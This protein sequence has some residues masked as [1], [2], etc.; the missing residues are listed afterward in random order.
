MRALLML[1]ILILAAAPA[2]PVE[3]LG[4]VQTFSA[5][6]LEWKE[7]RPGG[8][9]RTI[10]E[11][12]PKVPGSVVTYAFHMP[13]GAWFRPHLHPTTARVFVLRGTL[14]LGSGD[15]G[16]RAT[17]RRIT[18]GEV[19]IVPGNVHHYEGAEG[20]TVLIGVTTGPFETHFIAKQ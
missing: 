6:T 14:L 15:S 11:G 1:P 17:V 5:D 2:R 8:T 12:D 10:L 13:D 3:P 7:A 16:D 9:Q 4:A 18:A 20:D 19:V